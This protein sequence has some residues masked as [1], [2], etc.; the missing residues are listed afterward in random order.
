[1]Y[2]TE[3]VDEAAETAE[4][5]QPTVDTGIATFVDEII[6]DLRRAGQMIGLSGK[7]LTTYIQEQLNAHQQ[8]KLE[9]ERQKHE[10]ERQRHEAEMKKVEAALEAERQRHEAEMKKFKPS[11]HPQ[12]PKFASIGIMV[13]TN[14]HDTQGKGGEIAD[15]VAIGMSAAENLPPSIQTCQGSLGGTPVTV[16]L[17]S[18]CST[19]G[20]RRSLLRRE[21][22]LS[23]VQLC[24]LFNGQTVR[25]PVALVNL[26]CPF[27]SG[28]VE[29]CVIDNPVC[30]VIL[31]RVDGSTFHCAQVAAAA[32]T[33]AQ[34]PRQDKPF[35]PL[36]TT[37][38]PQLDIT[39]EKLAE[40]QAADTSLSTLF[41]KL[42]GNSTRD[43]DP[44]AAFV[45]RDGLLYRRITGTKPQTVTWQ[46]VV[47]K[48]LRESVLIAAHD[49]LFGGHMGANSTFKRITPFFFW[50]G[51]SQLLYDTWTGADND[52]VTATT[53]SQYVSDL[54]DA[55]RDMV[56][57][58]QDAVQATSKKNRDY[59]FRQAGVRSFQEALRS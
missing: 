48:G 21:Q 45:L 50:P 55:L 41:D 39:P 6:R 13:S 10:S 4:P 28:T 2:D 5:S 12:T 36:L 27:F 34:A 49:S 42:G 59:K 17:D 35:R 22:F 9:S 31:G 53:T 19:V 33:R 40:L 57:C 32:H 30:D 47:P 58:A 24:R 51:P 11:P 8:Q 18:G 23:K 44:A 25:L 43:R 26:D 29:A 15:E 3:V 52:D 46:V 38:T 7:A 37:K 56:R 20:V 14:T 16:M 54:R 1:M